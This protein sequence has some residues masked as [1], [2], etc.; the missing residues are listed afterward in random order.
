MN[1]AEGNSLVVATTQNKAG[2]RVFVN[3]AATVWHAL[4]TTA[5]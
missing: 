3:T 2:E 4:P 1:T 5:T